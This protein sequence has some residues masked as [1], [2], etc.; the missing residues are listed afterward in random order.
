MSSLT[1]SKVMQVQFFSYDMFQFYFSTGPGVV[2]IF[3]NA[4]DTDVIS[5]ALFSRNSILLSLYPLTI[6]ECLKFIRNLSHGV[7]VRTFVKTYLGYNQLQLQTLD[8]S[9]FCMSQRKLRHYHNHHH[10]MVLFL[11]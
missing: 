6:F 10:Q 4:I 11:D 9:K 1:G 2:I 7:R 3:G 8:I 5:S